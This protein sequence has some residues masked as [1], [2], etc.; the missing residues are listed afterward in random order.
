MIPVSTDAAATVSVVDTL[1]PAAVAVMVA[2]APPLEDEADAGKFADADP[3]GMMSAAGT[4]TALLF[5]VI[6]TV[7]PLDNATLFRVAVHVDCEPA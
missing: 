5:D 7:V 4:V 3:A 1:T 6:D 2:V